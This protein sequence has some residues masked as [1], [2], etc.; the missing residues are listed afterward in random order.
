MHLTGK[1]PDDWPGRVWTGCTRAWAGGVTG[2]STRDTVQ[3]L[4]LGPPGDFGTG[5]IPKSAIADVTMSRGLPLAVD[6]VRVKHVSGRKSTLLF[7]SYE[8]GREK[9]QGDTLDFVWFDEEPPEDIY[10]EGL[11]RTNAT[12]GM[13]FMTFTPLL[14][15]SAVARRFFQERN[16]SR[17]LTQMT[18]EDVLHY[19]PEQREA[20]LAGYPEHE[21]EARA[22]GIPM[23]GSGR[24]FPIAESEIV[25]DPISIPRHWPRICGIDFGW[26]HPTTAVWLAWDRDSDT[27]YVTDCYKESKQIPTV[28]SAAI[29][30]RGAWIPVAWPHDGLQ[31]EK[32]T[33]VTVK[34]VYAGAGLA[35]L[36]EPARHPD[37]GRSVES[38][39]LSMFERMT[40]KQFKVFKHLVPWM[41]EFR[42]YHRKDGKIVKEF[43]DLMDATRY[44]LMMLRYA[45]TEPK[46]QYNRADQQQY[47][48][49]TWMST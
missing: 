48:N 11:T 38:G 40:L 44:A 14:G 35:M 26:D 7:K 1:Y 18:I 15:M 24:I 13:A 12:N 31:T 43:D 47:D 2:M 28:H 41:E 42:L 22:K 45:R 16:P 3:K 8:M 19:T 9:W 36:P 34:E 5:A 10:S 46:G 39:L 20:I 29:R 30:S 33:G 27:V 25:I 21:R 6:T 23:M 37:G 49:L 17:H 32:G 4:L